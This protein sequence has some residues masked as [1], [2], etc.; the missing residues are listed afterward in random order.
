M[1]SYEQKKRMLSFLSLI[2]YKCYF[3]CL[4]HNESNERNEM[5]TCMKIFCRG[6]FFSSHVEMSMVDLICYNMHYDLARERER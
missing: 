6:F 5:Y 1:T 3:S 4:N 2:D